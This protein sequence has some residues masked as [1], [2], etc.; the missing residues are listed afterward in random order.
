MSKQLR[1][2]VCGDV[3]KSGRDCEDVLDFSEYSI[4]DIA[5]AEE[6]VTR[7]MLE[8]LNNTCNP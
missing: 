1:C 4:S 7:F 2:L 3:H 8:E 5:A 6:S